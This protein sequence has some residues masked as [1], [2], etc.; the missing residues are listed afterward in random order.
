MEKSID[1]DFCKFLSDGKVTA[2]AIAML[3][4]E[5]ITSVT[6][7]RALQT[8]DLDLVFKRIYTV[9]EHIPIIQLT[10]LRNLLE[11]AR[12]SS[13]AE[14]QSPGPS[15]PQQQ[16]QYSYPYSVAYSCF[17]SNRRNCKD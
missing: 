1:D 11:T 9:N 13:A 5:G 10:Y 7:F 8:S 2:S 17:Y 15:E 12:C 4:E 3:K 16:G 14:S 6:A